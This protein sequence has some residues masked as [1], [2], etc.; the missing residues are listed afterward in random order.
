LE[1]RVMAEN[2]LLAAFLGLPVV[3]GF[4]LRR[5]FRKQRQYKTATPPR[6]LAGNA[7]VLAFLCAIVVLLGEIHYRFCF[8]STDSFG[9]TKTTQRWFGRHFQANPSGIRDTIEYL[10]Q[11]PAGKRRV[12]FLGDSFTAGHGVADVEDRF[13]NQIRAMRPDWE[14]HILASLGW[15]TEPELS[16]LKLY[17]DQGFQADAVVLIYCLNDIADI[18]PE[19]QE[20]LRGI[21]ESWTPGFLARHSYFFN[22]LYYRW[23]ASNNPKISNYYHFVLNSYEGPVWEQQR[24]RLHALSDLVDSQGGR[25]LVVTFPFVDSLGPD[26]RY[27]RVHERLDEVWRNLEVPHLDLLSAFEADPSADLVVNSHDPHPNERAHAIAAE[28]IAAFI[29][30]HLPNSAPP[31]E[32]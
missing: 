9:L 3:L 11:V 20:I 2:L 31:D 29:D 21:Y 5:F 26:Y 14:I 12:T 27:R 23:K 22:T 15:D 28:S 18:L 10:Q 19:W 17:L 16:V 8:D 1:T 24:L 13:A 30:E 32:R 4:L 6:L 7:L 25:L